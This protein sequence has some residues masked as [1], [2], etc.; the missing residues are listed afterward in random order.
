MTSKEVFTGAE[1]KPFKDSIIVMFCEVRWRLITIYNPYQKAFPSELLAV[2]D[3]YVTLFG[4]SRSTI[5]K[6]NAKF[7]IA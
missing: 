4:V 6:P 1:L 7:H 2:Q 5:C 3:S